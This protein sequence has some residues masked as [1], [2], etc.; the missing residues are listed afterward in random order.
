MHNFCVYLM[1][2]EEPVPK[3]FLAFNKNK[4]IW[5]VSEF[6]SMQLKLRLMWKTNSDLWENLFNYY[7]LYNK[8][9]TILL[10]P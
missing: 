8:Y 2:E 10:I 5:A 9:N 3:T 4:K 1:A 7:C 6:R